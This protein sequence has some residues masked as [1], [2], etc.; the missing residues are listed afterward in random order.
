MG[1][2]DVV[3]TV[4]VGI[5]VASVGCASPD[6]PEASAD[7]QSADCHA[8]FDGQ[9]LDGWHRIGAA[10]FTADNGMIVGRA[11]HGIPNSFL[12]SDESYGDFDLS[13]EF[14]VDE[15]FNSGVQFRS[16]QASDTLHFRHQAGSGGRFTQITRPG[17]VWGYQADIDPTP[18]GWTAHIYEE[19]GRGWLQTL[20]ADADTTL[21][22]NPI[23][24]GAWHTL[25]I[26]A[27]GDTMRTW[28]DHNPVATLVDTLRSDGFIAL[29]VHAV[30]SPEEA[31]KTVRF[32][33]ISVC[34]IDT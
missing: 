21:K 5:L 18:R 28:L 27:E 12:S 13:L 3:Y 19:A 11:M 1:R 14:N 30:G 29:Q 4:L 31:G 34:P 26:R 17:R 20:A 24:P 22:L 25:R 6:T 2:S 7:T 9:S 32:R 23:D 16:A 33:S 15:A 8:L 10:D